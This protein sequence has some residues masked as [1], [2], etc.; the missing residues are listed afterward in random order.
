MFNRDTA[1]ECR[2]VVQEIG[3]SSPSENSTK[4]VCDQVPRLKVALLT[5]LTVEGSFFLHSLSD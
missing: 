5:Y 1:Q 3:K 4:K 2:N